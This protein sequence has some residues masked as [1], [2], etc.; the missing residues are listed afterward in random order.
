MLLHGLALLVC[1]VLSGVFSGSETGFYTVSRLRIDARARQGVRPAIL[2]RTLLANEGALLVTLL[3]GNNLALELATHLVETPID[4]LF[5]LPAASRELAVTL[6]LT[7]V[8]FLFGELLPK[9]LF[10]RRPHRLVG[11][12]AP[13]VLVAHYVLIPLTV[14]L[15]IL[16]AALHRLLGSA[17]GGAAEV[18][19]H[20]AVIELLEQGARQGTLEPHAERLARNALELR[21][22][23]IERAMVPWSRV[24]TIAADLTEVELRAEIMGARHTRLPVVDEDGAIQRYVHQLDVLAGD[25]EA[26]VLE[27]AR[28][29][30][31]L[32]PGTPVGRALSIL[33]VRGQRMALVG[34]PK[35]PVGI[36]TLKDLVE[37][38]SGP[39]A[40]F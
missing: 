21:D 40:G 32:D 7:P 1:L 14:P 34:T 33:R 15:R 31:A 16:S 6:V 19:G 9:D 4:E 26:S 37:E 39:L 3:V 20:E 30:P 23:P 25:A 28:P 13:L 8:V 29:L 5:E 12:V 35:A 11:L 18:A 38:I 2:I 22:L 27:G 17:Q 24:R 10:R 36:V